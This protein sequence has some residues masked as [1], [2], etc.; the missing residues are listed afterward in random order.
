M[1]ATRYP[2]AAASRISNLTYLSQPGCYVREGLP[3][4]DQGDYMTPLTVRGNQFALSSEDP[5]ASPCGVTL[6]TTLCWNQI[7]I[8]YPPLGSSQLAEQRTL[9]DRASS[10]PTPLCFPAFILIFWLSRV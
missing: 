7:R 6:N 2:R 4:W 3:L 10:H 8:F 9:I 1:S 5:L